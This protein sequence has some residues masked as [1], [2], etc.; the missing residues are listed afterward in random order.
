MTSARLD[1]PLAQRHLSVLLALQAH[2]RP[3]A[4][5]LTVGGRTWSFADAYQRTLQLAGGLAAVGITAGARVG[6]LLPNC[7]EFVFTWFAAAHLG[8]TTVVMNPQLR[9]PMLDL[10]LADCGCQLLV[11]H[12]DGLQAAAPQAR[13]LAVGGGLCVVV[14]TAASLPEG[15]RPFDELAAFS[16]PAPA[17]AGDYRSIQTVSFTS[18]S[19]GPAKGVRVTNNQAI[20]TAC[21]FVHAM[22]LTAEDV[23]FTPFA[24]FH[25]MSNR[26]AVVPCL[27]VGAHVV[28]AEG[29]SASHYWQ[30]AAAC[31]A[32]V[33]QTLPTVNAMLKSQPPGPGDRAH[34]V[35]RMYNSRVDDA[36]EQR[37]GVR[38]VEAYGMTEIGVVLYTPYGERRAGACGRIHPGWE[39][40]VLDED[41]WPL[42]AGQPG[43]LAFR[44][45]LPHLLCAGYMNRPQALVDATTNLWFHT[46]DVGRMDADGYVFFMDRRKERIRRRGENIS[47]FDAEFIV[48]AHPAVREC[49]VLPHPA[50]LGE[51]DVRLVVVA[52]PAAG[53]DGA[54]L[55]DW[56]KPRMPRFMLPRYIEFVDSLPRTPNNKIEKFKLVAAGLPAD[57]W[58]AE[59]AGAMARGSGPQPAAT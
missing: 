19:T 44:P 1:V 8:A 25:G 48:A 41:D 20:D 37:F 55:F 43:E 12:A 59:A 32:T 42:P 47:S 50:A 51:D 24:L 31:G 53:L 54:A 18:G 29:F 40:Q 30:Q 4:P 10:A 3:D 15:H 16:G 28:L 2:A 13:A 38:L 58:D 34:R 7:A 6:V 49:A 22:A 9:G 11:L 35:T 56:L 57:V 33:A 46:G 39:M 27:V 45:R 5:F 17:R 21:T 26:L 52:D 36:F 14:G 23:L